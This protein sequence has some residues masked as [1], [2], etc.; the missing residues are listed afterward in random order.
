MPRFPF[1]YQPEEGL[2]VYEESKR[3]ISKS[4]R[5]QEIDDFA[6]S[7]HTVGNLIPH[8]LE[9]LWSGHF[10]PWIESWEDLQI[11]CSLCLLGL[12]KQAMVSLRSSLELGLLSVYWNL[13]DDGHKIVRQWLR[14]KEDT[15]RV[16]EIWKRLSKHKNF[17]S[18]QKEYDLKTRLLNLGHL[19]DY[20][21]TKGYKYSNRFG[22]KMGNLQIFEPKGF[23]IWFSNFVEVIEVLAIC[24]L[25]KYPLGTIRFP[26][27]TKF[28]IDKPSFGGLDEYEVDKLERLVGQDVFVKI[29][30]V[31]KADSK[32]KEITAW[33]QSLPDMTEEDIEHQ[34]IKIDKIE[35]ELSGL[36][37]WLKE[38]ET[39]F[40][41]IEDRTKLDA[42]IKMLTEWA[43]EKGFDKSPLERLNV[44]KP[45]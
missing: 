14:S 35:I 26:Y 41:H 39:L 25:I 12:Y 28:G 10:F 2:K 4:G 15:P 30:Q 6:W 45:R 27:G 17:S 20:A 36:D 13:N 37:N 8:T 19:H 42:R 33:V 34:V 16:S 24:H 29:V 44:P 22:I 21:H 11:S 3:Y 31:G 18:F 5:E 32:V 9:S 40:G 1:T 23:E 38:Q 43:K 7:Y